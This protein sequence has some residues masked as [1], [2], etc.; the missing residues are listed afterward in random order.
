MA[1]IKYAGKIDG[2]SLPRIQ[3]FFILGAKDIAEGTPIAI[4]DDNGERYTDRALALKTSKK[5]RIF[6]ESYHRK[7]SEPVV[8]VVSMNDESY[9]RTLKSTANV[10][11][12]IYENESAQNNSD[13]KFFLLQNSSVE[14][15]L[16][17]ERLLQT[18]NL[19]IKQ[20]ACKQKL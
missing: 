17:D 6:L 19:G 4:K 3:K 16:E 2:T 11:Y 5:L 8:V 18:F 1:N 9:S 13:V 7:H 12:E 20:R 15:I 10:I 14:L